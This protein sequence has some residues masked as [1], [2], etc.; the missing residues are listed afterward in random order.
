MITGTI[1]NAGKLF[2]MTQKWEQKKASGNFLKKDTKE[3]SP[4]E[5]QLQMYQEQLEKAREGNEYS[6]IYA[7]LQSGQELSLA[8]EDKLRS[9][10]PKMYMEYKAD[11]M[12]Q[13]AYEKRLKE[14]KTKE[15]AEK[16]HVTRMSGKLSELK[17]IINNPNIPKSEKLKEAQRIMGDTTKTAQIYHVFTKSEE[18]KELPTEEELMEVKP[19][20]AERHEEQLVGGSDETAGDTKENIQRPGEVLETEKEVLEEMF[21]LEKKHFGERPKAARIDVAL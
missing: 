14:C 12:E 3:L 21:E 13:E 10:D 16:L 17:S 15:E 6:A 4:Q 11:R 1:R 5:Q 2:E 19:A 8:E 9:K 20:E 7:K 18:F